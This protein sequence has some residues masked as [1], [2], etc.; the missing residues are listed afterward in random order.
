MKDHLWVIQPHIASG[1]F[2][3]ITTGTSCYCASMSSLLQAS[4]SGSTTTGLRR[5]S[6][7]KAS[8]SYNSAS[9]KMAGVGGVACSTARLFWHTC[10]IQLRAWKV[11]WWFTL[12]EPPESVCQKGDELQNLFNEV[13]A[14]GHDT[15]QSGETKWKQ[16]IALV[17]VESWPIC[18]SFWRFTH[19]H[20]WRINCFTWLQLTFRL[21]TRKMHESAR[22]WIPMP[23][24]NIKMQVHMKPTRCGLICH[25]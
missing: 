2:G 15:S 10:I 20:T 14:L 21:I 11:L 7:S 16:I 8:G 12:F 17:H 18:R 13:C 24:W 5:I 1:L 25:L 19:S 9:S 3:S 22:L 23:W 6:L 4:A